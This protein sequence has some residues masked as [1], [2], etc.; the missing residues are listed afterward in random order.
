[1]PSRI[2][3][4]LTPS[5][6]RWLQRVGAPRSAEQYFAAPLST[7]PNVR[8]WLNARWQ[9]RKCT[10]VGRWT[11][12]N[13]HLHIYNRGRIVLGERVQ[14]HSHFAHSVLATF[15][16]GRLAVGDRTILNY[17]VDIAATKLVE[18]GPDCMIGTHVMM[19]DSDFHDVVHHERVPESR[20][21]IIGAAVWI[22]NRAVILPGVTIGD[23]AAIGAGS[24]VMTD[25][26][27]RSLAMGNPARVIR[28]F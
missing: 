19:L 4:F 14:L 7:W 9:L 3:Q 18:I 5:L 26:P 22:G 17:G 25:I 28:K 13:G 8:G 11:R 10:T 23:G 1:M 21:I 24:V 12:V 6:S 15:P 16:G 2:G 20:P 27:A